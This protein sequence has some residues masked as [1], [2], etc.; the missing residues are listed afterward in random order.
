MGFLKQVVMKPETFKD[1]DYS[2]TDF[3]KVNAIGYEG[4]TTY[5]IGEYDGIGLVF[6]MV[7]TNSHVFHITIPMCG[8]TKDGMLFEAFES[9]C[10]DDKVI[11]DS[12]L[13]LNYTIVSSMIRCKDPSINKKYSYYYIARNNKTTKFAKVFLT[14]RQSIIIQYTIDYISKRLEPI[15]FSKFAELIKYPKFLEKK[16]VRYFDK[17]YNLL[18]VLYRKK[19]NMLSVLISIENE[20]GTKHLDTTGKYFI[21]DIKLDKKITR[22]AKKNKIFTDDISKFLLDEDSKVILDNDIYYCNG[23]NECNLNYNY[24]P[25][26]GGTGPTIDKAVFLFPRSEYTEVIDIDSVWFTRLLEDLRKE[27]IIFC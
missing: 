17:Q 13:N 6:N 10:I 2:H 8:Y 12:A 20:E 5:N 22:K 9:S 18:K 14:E 26:G 11:I 1:F 4:T 24:K 23:H 15:P 3:L 19:S 21:F 27:V 16:H 25:Y 7:N